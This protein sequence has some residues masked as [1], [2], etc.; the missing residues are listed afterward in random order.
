MTVLMDEANTNQPGD[1]MPG[2]SSDTAVLDEQLSED[3]FSQYVTFF[4]ENESFAFPMES[5]LEIIRVPETVKVPLT[6]ESLVGLANLRGSVLP[7]L[8]LRRIL[9]RYQSEYDDATR[10]IVSNCGISAGL[11][12]DRVTRVLNVEQENIESAEAVNSN[13]R[14]ELLTG[15]I[16]NI[17]GF[18][19]IQLLDIQKIISL[20]YESVLHNKSNQ[21]LFS[22]NMNQLV[23]SKQ[24]D[25]EQEENT[26]QL[27]DFVVDNQEYAF[28]ISKVEEIIRVP[29]DLSQV[30]HVESHVLGMINLRNRLLPLVSLRRMFALSDA[31]IC[32]QNRILVLRLNENGN[33]YDSVGLVVDQVREVLR[34]SANAQESMPNLLARKHDVNEIKNVCRLNEGKRLV[35]V[36]SAEAMFK[37][38]EMQNALDAGQKEQEEPEE[39]EAQNKIDLEDDTQLVVFKLNNEEYGV[40]IESVQEIIRIPEEMSRIPKTANFI[41]GMVNLRGSVLPVLDMRVRFDM[42][43]ME[44]NEGQRIL[45][46]NLD[47][48]QTGF[49]V[50][51]LT[52]VLRLP[53]SV[54]ETSPS[55]S[56]EQTRIMGQVANLKE[57]NRMILVI[58]VQ[59]LLNKEELVTLSEKL[60]P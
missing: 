1:F 37:R 2:D 54:I 60:T 56:S 36:L 16:K 43:R 51:S 26:I 24:S 7:V 45:V 57:S 41:E 6:P 5:V 9:N 55:L 49:I 38:P 20:E 28:D 12:V 21:D 27:V 53:H 13:V 52:E 8:D 59:E 46:L 42:E 35:S 11:I 31:P 58:D 32:E 3:T 15:V 47:G 25:K 50:D 44:R 14:S 34:V 39:M 29:E 22:A 17:E 33:G 48:V 19:L 4:I 30:P 10:V 23:D 40:S 18:K